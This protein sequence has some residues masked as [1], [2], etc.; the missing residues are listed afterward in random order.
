MFPPQ[1]QVQPEDLD[2]ALEG[3]DPSFLDGTEEEIPND[4]ISTD[5]LEGQLPPIGDGTNADLGSDPTNPEGDLSTQDNQQLIDDVRSQLK[6]IIDEFDKLEQPTREMMIRLWRRCELFWKG[7]HNIY[8]DYQARDYRILGADERTEKEPNEELDYY[9]QDKIVNIFRAHGESV[10]SALS[11]DVPHVIFPP[12]DADNPDDVRTS[13]A[14]TI[15]SE[16]LQKCNDA[17]FLLMYGIYI[18][19]N[20]GLIGAYNY[21]LASFEYGSITEPRFK[22]IEETDNEYSCPNCG[23]PMQ[24]GDSQVCPY[25]SQGQPVTPILTGQTQVK[26]KIYSHDEQIPKKREKIEFFGPLNIKIPHYTTHPRHTPYVDLDT[27]CHIDYARELYP[28]ID[29]VEEN[30]L[31]R[32]DRWARQNTDY[33]GEFSNGLVTL[34]RFWIRPWVFNRFKKNNP[35][36]FNYLQQN[37]PDGIK[38]VLVN[39]KI[40]ECAAENLDEHWTFTQSPLSTYLHALPIGAPLLP[41][42]EMRNELVV[43]K[44]QTVEY[45]IPESFADPAVLDF[46]QYKKVENSP[47]MIFPAKA[48]PGQSLESSFA[49][50]KTATFPKEANDFQADLDSDGQFVTGAFPS[51]YGGSMPSAS[52]TAAEYQMSRNQALQRLQTTWKIIAKFWASVMDKSTRSFINS[53]EKDERFVQ[54]KGMSFINVYIRQAEM[55]GR[56]GMAEPENAATFPL[57][58]MQKRDGL[59]QLLQLGNDYINEALFHPENTGLLSQYMGFT[60]FYIPGNDS[61]TKQLNEIQILIGAEPSEPDYDES[62]LPPMVGLGGD[63]SMQQG[64]QPNQEMQNPMQQ[65]IPTVQVDPMIDNHEIEYDTCVSWLT[66]E[67]GQDAKINNPG[68]YANVYA[69]A[70]QHYQFVMR[71]QAMQQQQEQQQNDNKDKGQN[72]GQNKPNQKE[73]VKEMK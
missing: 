63:A 68:G 24:S 1:A 69:H 14:Y 58:W 72:S 66:S 26:K 70:Q 23:A 44:L 37:F 45:G 17:E 10:I 19:W 36:V 55:T 46:D 16:L 12:D 51:I 7:I 57:S 50:L 20:Q 3:T 34:R 54:R 53:L 67:V 33:Q 49:T 9:Y 5:E 21:N 48:R 56:V 35:E 65:L 42:Q 30:D 73:D 22:E 28:D 29:I 6:G 27:E 47:G 39:D 15:A 64:M 43:M 41:I 13:K 60:D 71:N 31:E 32:F 52:K 25:C 40:A 18:L 2:K 8:W 61:R 62:Q 59:L 38:V 4:L 11:Q